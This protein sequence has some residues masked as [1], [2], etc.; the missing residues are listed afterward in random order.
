MSK[1]YLN[2]G[3]TYS[4]QFAT[5]MYMKYPAVFLIVWF[6]KLSD[7]MLWLSSYTLF[8]AKHEHVIQKSK[9]IDYICY[10]IRACKK[11]Y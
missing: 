3:S 1:I 9:I 7:W 10:Y 6:E 4:F 2:D 5:F 8:H 11:L